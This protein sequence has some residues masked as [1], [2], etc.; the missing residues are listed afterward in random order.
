MEAIEKA[1]TGHYIAILMDVQMPGMNGFDATRLIREYEK[2][3][4]KPR[5]LIIGMTAHALGGDRERCLAVGMDDYISKP[6]SPA[7]LKSKLAEAT[8][9]F[10]P[11]GS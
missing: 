3:D 6:F 10:V 4:G 5:V 2:R 8:A 1:K 9:G 7:M 11:M